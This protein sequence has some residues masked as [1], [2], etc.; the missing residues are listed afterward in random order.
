MNDLKEIENLV[1]TFA[2]LADIKEAKGQGELFLK[3]GI[4]EFQRGFEGE[5]KSIIGREA[6]VNAFK[7][8]IEPCVALYHLNG[9]HVIE[10]N[11]DEATGTAYCQA[12]L[13]NEV[14]GKQMITVN[15]VRYSDVYQKVE[16][17]WYIKKRR[18]TFLISD[19]HE[20]QE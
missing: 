14:E 9:Q 16:G 2:N 20:L 17:R 10:L 15:N 7:A 6:I 3:E 13:V 11:G 12:T 5:I 1:N 19:T 4:L 18:T 8:T